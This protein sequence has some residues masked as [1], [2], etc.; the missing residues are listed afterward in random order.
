MVLPTAYAANREAIK[1]RKQNKIATSN[2]R[3]N[4]KRVPFEYEVGTK[5]LLE[6][7]GIIR[8]LSIPRQGPY[9]IVTVHENGTVTI[10]L[11]PNITD[12]VNIRRL[13][14]YF[15]MIQE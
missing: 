6:R 9:E 12:R 13:T 5:V 15:E 7:P 2:K 4:S 11:R 1:T 3:E 10:Q 8:K 14:P